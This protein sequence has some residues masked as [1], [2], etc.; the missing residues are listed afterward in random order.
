MEWIPVLQK[1]NYE[2]IVF[3]SNHIP[4]LETRR[5]Q[6]AFPRVAGKTEDEKDLLP[7]R[8]G[9]PFIG[10]RYSRM[11]A[12][13]SGNSHVVSGE[14]TRVTEGTNVLTPLQCRSCSRD[15]VWLSW[16]I[17]HHFPPFRS[18]PD[19]IR[20]FSFLYRESGTIHCVWQLA[21]LR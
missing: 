2:T 18:D 3:L 13:G 5:E 1:I 12:P 9:S 11:I 16:E 19:G 4:S 10:F 14:V 20:L 7:S 6:K 21:Y 17:K 15:L 8:I